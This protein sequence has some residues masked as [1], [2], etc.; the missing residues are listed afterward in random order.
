[1]FCNE[2]IQISKH[3]FKDFTVILKILTKQCT[4]ENSY[5]FMF[6]Y[7]IIFLP[8]SNIHTLMINICNNKRE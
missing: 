3:S 2:I 5:S 8:I 7:N 1:M 6:F 4:I